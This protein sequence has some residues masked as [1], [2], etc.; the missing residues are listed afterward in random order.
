MAPG[1]PEPCLS[2]EVLLSRP[3]WQA[4]GA[5]RASDPNLFFT[6][7][8]SPSYLRWPSTRRVRSGPNA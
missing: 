8:G 6:A 3:N 4:G 7:G 5:C 2:A 1:V